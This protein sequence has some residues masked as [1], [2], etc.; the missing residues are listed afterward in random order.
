MSKYILWGLEGLVLHFD[1]Q[2]L[3]DSRSKTNFFTQTLSF[4]I[5]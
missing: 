4:L 1:W 5:Y 2:Y 3:I